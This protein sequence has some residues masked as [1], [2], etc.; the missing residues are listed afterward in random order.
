MAKQIKFSDDARQKIF[1]GIEKVAKV[2][3][4]TMGPKGRN[5]ILDKGYGAPQITNDG[6]TIAKEIDLED[7]FEALG[8]ELV[9][10]AA[11]KTNKLA[12]DGTTT[13]TLLTYALAKEGLRYIKN[14]VNSVELKNGMRKA[15][16]RVNEELVKNAKIINTKEEIAQ[17]ATISAQ[18]EEVGKI[19]ALAM[20]KVGNNGVITVE[21]GQTFGLDVEVTEGM[22][23]DQG[24]VSPYM[25]TNTEKMQASIKDAPILITDSKISSMK[26]LLPVLEQLVQSGRKDLVIIA[27]DIDG[28]ALTTIILNKLKGVLSILGIKAPGFGDRKK[29]MLKDIAVLVGANVITSELG[30]KLENATLEDL[31]QASNVIAAKDKTIIVGGEGDSSEIK[32]RVSQISQEIENTTSDYDKEKLHER[33]AKLSGGV[34]VIKVGAASEVEMKEKKLRIEDAL[35]ATRAAVEEGVVAGGGVALLKASQVLED[36]DL[37]NEYQNIGVSI[38]KQALSYPIRQI[39][40]NA[41]KEGSVI[42]NKILEEK[43]V[44]FGYNA[45]TDIYVDMVNTGIIDPKKVERIALEEAI[46]LAGM[47][48][49]TEAAVTDIPKKD[50]GCSG[51]CGHDAG[52]G[53][54][55]MPGMGMY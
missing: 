39:V 48:L 45:A 13:A 52:M 4:V 2:V 35:N 43:S 15:G 38:V 27:D 1:G 37:G 21:E 55:G 6:V 46:S 18:D 26:D 28:E 51:S 40:E 17:V 42:I 44:N 49:T 7:K 33:L 29:E 23:F 22:Q 10:E 24:Y 14:G 25:V 11:E 19:I 41:G 36:M 53:G 50:G 54:M 47:F 34:A 30:M 3:T 16:E 12:G 31:G 9:K 20:E 8:A 5:V 32:N